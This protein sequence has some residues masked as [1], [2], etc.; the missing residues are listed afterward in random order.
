MKRNSRK[1]QTSLKFLNHSVSFSSLLPLRQT[2]IF[3]QERTNQMRKMPK[4]TPSTEDTRYVRSVQERANKLANIKTAEDSQTTALSCHRLRSPS[5]PNA[6][7]PR[8]ELNKPKNRGGTLSSIH[9]LSLDPAQH[10]IIEAVG[11]PTPNRSVNRWT[12]LSRLS[13][14]SSRQWKYPSRLYFSYGAKH[15]TLYLASGAS[16][17]TGYDERPAFHGYQKDLVPSPTSSLSSSYSTAPSS[18]L[19][20]P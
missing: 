8:A 17:S 10:P 6:A 7:E 3:N 20:L 1:Q 11:H 4:T 19:R 12:I 9:H 5:G 18:S 14:V 13:P 16:L 15:C 2:S